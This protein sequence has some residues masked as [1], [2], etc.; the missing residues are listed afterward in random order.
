[1]QYLMHSK[2]AM[3]QH[4]PKVKQCVISLRWGNDNIDYVAE[5]YVI[6]SRI[7]VATKPVL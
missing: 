4:R 1:M 6:V 2:V 7:E 5:W 3:V